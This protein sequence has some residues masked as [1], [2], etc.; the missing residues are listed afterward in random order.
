MPAKKEKPREEMFPLN[1]T[2][3]QRESLVHGTRLT[4]KIKTRIQEAS[5]DQKF[6]EF[7]RKELEK[8]REEIDTSLRYVAPADRKQLNAVLDKID[9]LRDVLEEKHWA[10]NVMPLTSPVPSTSSR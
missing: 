1:L 6:V 3:K 4:P 7:T 8:M 2:V 5:A 9:E 10:R